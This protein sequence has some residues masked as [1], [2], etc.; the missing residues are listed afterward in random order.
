MNRACK[1]SNNTNLVEITKVK[2]QVVMLFVCWFLFVL[3]CFLLLME[4]SSALKE[5][6]LSYL[7]AWR[8]FPCI[9]VCVELHVASIQ[10]K[11]KFMI[12]F[13]IW[14][15]KIHDISRGEQI[16]IIFIVIWLD[17]DHQICKITNFF[18]LFLHKQKKTK[19]NSNRPVM[20]VNATRM[21]L[22]R[23]CLFEEWGTHRLAGR[24]L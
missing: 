21:I 6:P 5:H 22:Q 24:L 9:F 7:S 23:L 1:S 4:I 18:L 3:L 11:I 10:I 14:M 12:N 13:A 2:Y 19:K 17:F 16:D 15:N 20:F 8:F